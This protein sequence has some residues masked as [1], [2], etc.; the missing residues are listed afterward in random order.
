MDRAS[1]EPPPPPPPRPSRT[2]TPRLRFWRR[3]PRPQCA[4]CLHIHRIRGL[5]PETNGKYICV[6]W[7]TNSDPDDRRKTSPVEVRDGNASIDEVLLR[8]CGSVEEVRS[9][10]KG[11]VVSVW[12]PGGC[13][14]GRPFGVDLSEAAAVAPEKLNSGN[15]GKVVEFDL[16][17]IYNG[18]VLSVGVFCRMLDDDE[19]HDDDGEE[20][21][22]NNKENGKEALLS[23]LHICSLNF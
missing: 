18:G 13:G 4:V 1:P 17:G 9:A 8:Y 16:E 15:G 5:P 20:E 3:R 21:A 23:L 7:R 11:T 22:I 2:K 12:S 6:G 19:Y 14:M 10:L